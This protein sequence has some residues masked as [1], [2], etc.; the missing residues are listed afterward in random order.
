[1]GYKVITQAVLFIISLVIIFTYIQPTFL[2]IK[3]T[4]DEAFQYADAAAKASEFNKQLA[5]LVAT[6]NKFRQSDIDALDDY[7]PA[8]ID[9]MSVMAD[10]TYMTEDAGMTLT[11]LTSET[12][13]EPKKK[14]VFAGEEKRV[15]DYEHRDYTLVAEGKYTDFKKMLQIFERNKYPLEITNIEFAADTVTDESGQQVPVNQREGQY[16]LVLRAYSFS[17]LTN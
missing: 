14:A 6:S 17:N 7:L 3:D 16:S 11:S 9:D 10:V 4:Q 1:M 12:A 2:S 13:V 15:K 8:S 5:S